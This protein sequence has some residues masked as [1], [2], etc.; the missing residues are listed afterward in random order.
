MGELKKGDKVRLIGGGQSCCKI[1]GIYEVSAAHGDSWLK[2][3]GTDDYGRFCHDNEFFLIDD[4][5]NHRYQNYPVD[6]LTKWE[7]VNV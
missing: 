4:D 2:F 6:A 3:D 7:K 1:G 5:G